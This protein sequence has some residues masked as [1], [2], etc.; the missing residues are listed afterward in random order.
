MKTHNTIDINIKIINE[1]VT[2]CGWVQRRRDH[3]GVIFL[4]IRD[5]TGIIQIKYEP[6]NE[7]IFKI[8]NNL[9]NEYVI[10]ASGTVKKR[11]KGNES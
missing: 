11:P 6:L 7:H 1:K 8:A 4:D 5:N 9:R 3:G 2:I 10:Q